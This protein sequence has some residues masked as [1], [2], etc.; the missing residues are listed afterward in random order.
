MHSRLEV[1]FRLDRMSNKR[2]KP[3]THMNHRPQQFSLTPTQTQWTVIQTYKYEVSKEISS[4]YL[5]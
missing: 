3:Q 5:L 1:C 2:Y 4:K